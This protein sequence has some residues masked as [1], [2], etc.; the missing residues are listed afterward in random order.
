MNI[1]LVQTA[2]L[3]DVVLS[4][5]VIEGLSFL[6]PSAKIFTLTTPIAE[7]LLRYN[8]KIFKT[9]VYDKH[10][11]SGILGFFKQA[12][13]LRQYNFDI[14]Y[15][16]QRSY[17]TSLLLFFTGIKKRIGF[18]KSKLS[19]LY[20]DIVSFDKLK[21]DAI[22]NLSI[23]S[24]DADIKNLNSSLKLY[25][26]S[27]EVLGKIF[28]DSIDSVGDYVLL[29]PGSV[30]KT[31]RWSKEQYRALTERLLKDGQK[32][33]ITGSL[34][35]KNICDEISDGLNVNNLVGKVSIEQTMYIASKAKAIVCNDSMMLHLSSAFKRPVVV[36]FCATS[37]SFGFGPWNNDNAVIVEN[38]ELKCKP[39]RRHGSKRCPNGTDACRKVSYLKVYEA[40][41]KFL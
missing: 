39:C 19:F 29:A 3:G 1:L 7:K 30:W 41:K 36:I 27:K 23:L 33:V 9:L 15:S 11:N 38:D 4:T 25:L 32:V 17:R 35:E 22:R 40:L 34:G 21:H 12:K 31:K 20:T 6:Y 18:K 16:L 13:I 26:P 24:L 5:P 14:V 8:P 2:F 37:P 28:V 10:K